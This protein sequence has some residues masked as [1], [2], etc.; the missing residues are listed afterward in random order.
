MAFEYPFM[1]K[2]ER[3]EIGAMRACSKKYRPL[4]ESYS[5]SL[6]NL[7]ATILIKDPNRRPDIHQVL[8]MPVLYD[9]LTTYVKSDIFRAEVARLLNQDPERANVFLKL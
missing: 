5:I 8:N 3:P 2:S 7:V 6:R 1:R 9:A 4:P